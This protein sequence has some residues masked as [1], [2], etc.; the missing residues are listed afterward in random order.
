V[1]LEVSVERRGAA[2]VATVAGEIDLANAEELE[3]RLEVGLDGADALIVDLLA[4]DYLDSSALACLHRVSLTTADR[5]LALRVVTGDRSMAQRLLAITGL[6]RVLRTSGSVD[7][8]LA[9]IDADG[10]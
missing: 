5:G 7:D 1:I 9:T 6:D 4:V 2:A 3:R 8:A 10:Q